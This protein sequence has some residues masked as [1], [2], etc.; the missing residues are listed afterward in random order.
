MKA[1]TRNQHPSTAETLGR[2]R[3]L[4]KAIVA[5][6]GL[7]GIVGCA[8]ADTVFAGDDLNSTITVQI[9]NYSQASP[10][11]LTGA[12]REAG[13]ILGASGVRAVWLDCP[14]GQSTTSLQERCQKA[15][16]A[17]DISMRVLAAP[18]QNKFEDNVFGFTVHPVL[19][20]VYYE[21]ALHL[22]V[23][24]GAEFEVPIILGCVI[25]HE[26]GHLLLG[27]NSH[28]PSG[29][30]QGEWRPKQ[31]HLALTGRLHFAS[32]QAKL[33]RAEARRRMDLKTGTPKEQRLA[34]VDPRA[35]PK[36]PE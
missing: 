3:L 31:I 33:I 17:T 26:L 34:T 27:P 35:E 23:R 16:E 10:A 7:I 25:A 14:V 11:V 8:S 18:I 24:E 20:S 9:Y 13:R 19:A 28:S 4:S 2:S 29:I 30:M 1:G 15:S 5:A 12:E 22:A 21:N 32:Q 36:F 6:M